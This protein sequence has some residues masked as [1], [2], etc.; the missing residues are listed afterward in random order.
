MKSEKTIAAGILPICT[1]TGNL[2]LIRR[3]PEQPQP[4]TYACLGGKKEDSD[5][6][7]AKTAIREFR[8]ETNFKEKFKV[9]KFPF[10]IYEDN[11]IKFYLFIGLFNEEFSIPLEE[12]YPPEAIDYAWFPLNMMPVDALMPE[13]KEAINDKYDVLKKVIEKNRR[14]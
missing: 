1:K 13:F 9:S 3:G 10:H 4:L 11:H 5:E 2:L 6:E 8:E 14:I 12:I 7:P